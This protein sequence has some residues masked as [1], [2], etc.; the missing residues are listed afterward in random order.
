MKRILIIHTGGTFGMVPERPK[1]TLRP[2]EVEQNI[3][4]HVPELAQLAEIEFQVAFNLDSADM[5]P[6]RFVSST[7]SQSASVSRRNGAS[8]VVPALRIRR[9]IRGKRVK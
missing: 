8:A 5:A 9:S 6:A 2:S 3:I 7:R 1:P 4:T